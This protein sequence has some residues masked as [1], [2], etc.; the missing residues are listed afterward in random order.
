MLL[1]LVLVLARRVDG[2]SSSDSSS[3][4]SSEA[5]KVRTKR[6]EESLRKVQHRPTGTVHPVLVLV[7]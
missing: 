5:T 3:D 2:Y 1:D 6:W 7:Y 4:S